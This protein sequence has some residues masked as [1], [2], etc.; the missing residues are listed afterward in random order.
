V[1]FQPIRK[2]RDAPTGFVVRLA[3]IACRSFGYHTTYLDPIERD[4]G[5]EEPLDGHPPGVFRPPR[6]LFPVFCRVHRTVYPTALSPKGGGLCPR[7]G[8]AGQASVPRA[9]GG[10]LVVSPFRRPSQRPQRRGCGGSG[11]VGKLGPPPGPFF[12]P[13]TRG[14]R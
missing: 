1:R 2:R 3:H 7:P 9:G 6:R 12:F 5:G 4:D 10:S 11:H 14:V 13:N 8:K